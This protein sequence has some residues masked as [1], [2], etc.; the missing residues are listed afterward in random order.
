MK[1]YSKSSKISSPIINNAWLNPAQPSVKIKGTKLQVY[2]MDRII[3]TC[4]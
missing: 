4:L 2:M 3:V 1:N